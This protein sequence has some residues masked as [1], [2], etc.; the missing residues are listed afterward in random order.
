[1]AHE[2]NELQLN[3]IPEGCIDQ[4]YFWEGMP[5]FYQER[6][7]PY[8][9]IIFRFENEDDLQDFANL[10][11]QKLTKKTKSS[12][13]PFKQHRREIKEVWVAK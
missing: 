1:M 12:W 3:N 11:G 6:R 4:N 5:E 7:E 8:A 13:H 2:Q 10:I 9:K